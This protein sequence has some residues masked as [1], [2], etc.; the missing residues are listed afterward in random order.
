MLAAT[1]TVAA[2][3]A[4]GVAKIGWQDVADA[5]V[6]LQAD[7]LECEAIWGPE[8]LKSFEKLKTLE[9]ELLL[10][11]QDNLSLIDPKTKAPFK[12]AIRKRIAGQK[13]DVLYDTMEE[14]GDEYSRDLRQAVDKIESR[15]RP[16]LKR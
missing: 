9:R 14:G 3:G 1:S 16:H 11:V 2:G 15:I 13:R 10:A 7:L 6:D 4:G 12:E 8:F 5:L